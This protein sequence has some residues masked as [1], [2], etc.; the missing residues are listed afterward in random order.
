MV[1]MLMSIGE[2]YTTWKY[3]ETNFVG[4]H[5]AD[6]PVGYDPVPG[7]QYNYA[8]QILYNP[9]LAIVK[10][11]LLLFLGR[12]A[13]Q[14]KGLRNTIWGLNILN[15]LMMV[16]IFIVVVFQ[17]W[18]IS[19]NWDLSLKGKCVQQGAFYVATSALTLFTDILVLLI[20]FWIVKD[21]KMPRKTKAAVIGIFLL[22]FIVTVIGIARL[23]IIAQG[24][25]P[26]GAVNSDPTYNIGFTTSAMET[27][28]A[29]I[30]ANAPALKPL[31]KK[32]FPRLFS[33]NGN[34]YS[35]GPYAGAGSSA[36]G[37]RKSVRATH[38]GGAGLRSGHGGFVLK[39]MKGRS[40][41]RSTNRGD[42]EEE[43]M[44][45][46]GI[47]KTTDVSVRYMDS[48]QVA[49]SANSSKHDDMGMRTSVDSAV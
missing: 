44:T 37:I 33:S 21:L 41:I 17:C 16:S 7:L 29:I 10:T 9:I 25:F 15:L 18:P 42:S 1:A 48:R 12:L 32:W 46:D 6:I 4:I 28:V 20:P 8:V 40:E 38:T 43:I 45:F 14:K 49:N 30:T 24:F 26:S 3:M 47:V 13:G 22:G 27:N 23:V 2:T 19:Y 36:Y 39:D 5:F 31:F 35:S 11:S 34:P